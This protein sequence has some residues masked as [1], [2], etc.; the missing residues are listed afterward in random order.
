M[1]GPSAEARRLA[2]LA[3]ADPNRAL[4]E[5]EH[6][7]PHAADD[8]AGWRQAA[9]AEAYDNLSFPE[10]ARRVARTAL[11][12]FPG[13]G[14]G[15]RVELLT[16]YAIN[17]YR[18]SEIDEAS[19]RILAA[20]RSQL[21]ASSGDV[22]LQIALGTLQ[23]MRGIADGAGNLVA[24]YRR[25]GKPEMVLQHVMAADKL[26]RVMGLAGDYNQA[27][28]LI[29]EVANWHKQN[30][31][32]YSL[33]ADYYFRGRFLAG[34]GDPKSAIAD[35]ERS[36]R[37]SARFDDPVGSAFIDL[38]TCNAL[39]EIKSLDRAEALCRRADT[40][41]SRYRDDGRGQTQLLLARIAFERGHP[42]AALKQLDQLLGSE[43]IQSASVNKSNI[44]KLRA[45]ADKALGHYREAYDN[46]ATYDHLTEER[47]R[48]EREKQTAV[49][50]ASFEADR[51][52]MRNL[53]L[54]R[55]LE[56]AHQREREKDKRYGVY[57]LAGLLALLSLV[58]VIGM[59]LIH[60][61]RLTLVANTDAL[62]GLLNR[63]HMIE[64]FGML[65]Q[66]HGRDSPLALAIID[67]DHFKAINDAYGHHLG[68]QVLK[69]FG[70]HARSQLRGNSLLARWG[71]EEFLAIL[72]QTGLAEALE[73]LS[74]LQRSV[75]A[76]ETPSGE[77]IRYD[78]SAGLA[79]REP[80][81]DLESLVQRADQALYSAKRSGRNRIC[82]A[83]EERFGDPIPL[84]SVR[85][86]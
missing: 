62:T 61:R 72:P 5:T 36:R 16:R 58:V 48:S 13:A 74:R 82:C 69:E 20:R 15:L 68:D 78:F 10:Q 47:S 8:L 56:F 52:A 60:R 65:T 9:R 45:Q 38:Q 46:L 59:G 30:G 83:G 3:A 14:S 64:Q 77:S 75:K 79:S 39:V 6:D 27:V 57:A 37:L 24:A 40:V 23:G 85:A 35:F 55:R 43:N 44:Y 19:P 7:D 81:E 11:Q 42:A 1:L 41:F 80:G 31:L 4:A 12:R 25:S 86:G 71:G 32:D 2:D 73:A 34:K 63:R 28:S 49:L 22:C 18:E 33:A 21:P 84:R 54:R 26:S 17:G 67:I 66:S 51:E 29:E 50:R 70:A 76:T 53:D